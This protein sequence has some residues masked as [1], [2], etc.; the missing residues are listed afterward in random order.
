[1]MMMTRVVAFS[2]S[3]RGTLVLVMRVRVVA[4]LSSVRQVLVRGST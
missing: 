2:F 3:P 4:L 1:M